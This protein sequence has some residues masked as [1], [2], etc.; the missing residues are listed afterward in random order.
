MNNFLKI[1]FDSLKKIFSYPEL[2]LRILLNKNSLL[3]KN[4]YISNFKLSDIDII[5][6]KKDFK[7]RINKEPISKIFNEKSFWKYEFFVNKEVLDPRPESELIIEQILEHYFDKNQTLKILDICTGSGC[8]AISIAKEYKNALITATDI[9]KKAISV[10]KINS[11]K[12]KC[13]K[14]LKFVQCDLLDK[15]ENYDIVIANPPYL[16]EEE[17]DNVSSEIKLFEPK[18]ALIAKNNGLEFYEKIANILPKILKTKSLA[19]IEIGPNQAEQVI[20]IFKSQNVVCLRI[21]KDIQNLNR[22]LILNKS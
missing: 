15:Y 1:Y 3:N 20:S 18:I 12:L 5:K 13:S 6:F 17:Y 19:F 10:A 21:V 9:S 16:S 4:I 11:Q 2:E 22:M 7:R 8:L 14:Q